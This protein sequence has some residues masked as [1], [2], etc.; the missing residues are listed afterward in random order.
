MGLNISVLARAA[1]PDSSINPLTKKY[2]AKGRMWEGHN[3][4]F[5]FTV[6]LRNEVRPMAMIMPTDRFDQHRKRTKFDREVQDL[7]QLPGSGC[8]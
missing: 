3:K 4:L 1:S 2:T 6:F 5:R 7:R 8:G